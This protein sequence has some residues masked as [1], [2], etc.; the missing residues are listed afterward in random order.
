MQTYLSLEVGG[1]KINV[2]AGQNLE[3]LSEI[4]R[5]DTRAPAETLPEVIA[6]MK[7]LSETHGQPAAIGIASF[8]P[9]DLNRHS[10]TYGHILETTKEK[11]RRFDLLGAIAAAFP[12]VPI[13][14]DTDVNGAALGEGRYGGAQGLTDF[15]YVTIGTGVGVGIIT[16]SEPVHGMLHPEAGHVGIRRRADDPFKGICSYHGD[17]L[18]GMISGPALA[19]RLGHG[20]ESLLPDDPLWE[21]CGDYLA[22][23][24][25]SVAMTMSAQRILIGGGVGLN[26]SLIKHTRDHMHRYMGGYIDA[27]KD[28]E[29]F[30]AYVAPAALGH[31]AGLAGGLVLAANCMP[32]WL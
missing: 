23:A 27:L 13:G 20:A 3:T 18:E 28:R 17:C 22:Q 21:L 25:C 10:K 16:N 14:L 15:A 29:A 32:V 6:A 1:T 2:A 31:K 12:D 11:W 8:G 30:D 5:V 26:Q 19:A 9:I 4:V 24:L 7:G